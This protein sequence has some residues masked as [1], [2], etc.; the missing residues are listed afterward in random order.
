MSD[1]LDGAPADRPDA[2]VTTAGGQCEP[3]VGISDEDRRL[4]AAVE[5]AQKE[6]H[7]AQRD[8]Y[9]QAGARREIL[10]ELL[11]VKFHLTALDFLNRHS[12]DVPA[13]LEELVVAVGLPWGRE[14]VHAIWRRR[15]L[16]QPDLRAIVARNLATSV[17]ES[18]FWDLGVLLY[19]LRDFNG[20]RA[21]IR[22]AREREDP[23]FDEVADGLEQ[24]LDVSDPRARNHGSDPAGILRTPREPWWDYVRELADELLDPA[25]GPGD[26]FTVDELD[27]AEAGL[28]LTL[29][30]AL[31]EA[32]ALFGRRR[33]LTAVQ[34][35]FLAPQDLRVEDG[36]LIYRV[37]AQGILAWGVRVEHLATDDPPVVRLSRGTTP[38]TQPWADKVSDDVVRAALAELVQPDGAG[39]T[40][41]T[42]K[43]DRGLDRLENS[44]LT[45]PAPRLTGEGDGR[46]WRRA[47]GALFLFGPGP[48]VWVRTAAPASLAWFRDRYPGPWRS[49]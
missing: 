27:A 12:E 6:L 4:W 15:W 42:D 2:G 9:L 47:D 40:A 29:P 36:V 32:Y 28:G 41:W 16:I 20:L 37:E 5:A 35:R 1:Q 22:L 46:T 14:A 44:T 23:E 31:R 33:E 26:G 18:D 24:L 49:A 25:L 48:S 45:T 11:P 10:A 3:S 34:D 39:T 19:E 38:G 21:V 8:F 13:L 43:L 17:Y 7:R 30:D